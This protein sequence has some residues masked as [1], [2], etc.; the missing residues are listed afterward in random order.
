MQYE[1]K[2]KENNE[3]IKAV[4][5]LSCCYCDDGIEDGFEAY[6]ENGEKV[7]NEYFNM[8]YSFE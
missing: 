2:N 7:E 3:K 6:K 1:N 8:L 4:K 5:Y